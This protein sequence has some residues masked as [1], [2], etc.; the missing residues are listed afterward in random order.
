MQA[1]PAAVACT[2]RIELRQRPRS[3][4]PFGAARSLFDRRLLA[5][6]ASTCRKLNALI[7]SCGGNDMSSD[8]LLRGRFSNARRPAPLAAG[9]GVDENADSLFPF[10]SFLVR[11][12]SRLCGGPRTRIARRDLA[13]AAPARP[14]LRRRQRRRRALGALFPAGPRCIS[15]ENRAGVSKLLQSMP[16]G[17]RV[18]TKT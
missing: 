2:L 14:P 8:A 3:D 16:E 15:T 7:F 13:S 6:G 18:K 1:L 9:G 5:R 10:L 17:R 11:W 4:R 12:R